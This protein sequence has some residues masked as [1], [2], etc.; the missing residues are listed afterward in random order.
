MYQRTKL[1]SF[2]TESIGIIPDKYSHYETENPRIYD[3]GFTYT[4]KLSVCRDVELLKKHIHKNTF[5]LYKATTKGYTPLLFCYLLNKSLDKDPYPNLKILI[6]EGADINATTNRRT[7]LIFASIY[8]DVR[9]VKLLINL[10]ANLDMTD[11]ESRTALFRGNYEI[12]KLLLE[13]GATISVDVLNMTPLTIYLQWD[14]YSLDHEKADI[15]L[16]YISKDMLNVSDRYGR[17]ALLLAKTDKMINKML[18]KG[19]DINAKMDGGK[20]VFQTIDCHISKNTMLRL[21]DNDV[22]TLYKLFSSDQHIKIKNL[23]ERI[24]NIIISYEKI[25]NDKC[26]TNKE[27]RVLLDDKQELALQIIIEDYIYET[28]KKRDTL[29]YFMGSLPTEILTDI[30]KKIY[31]LHN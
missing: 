20:T 25:E 28:T 4:H 6:D 26:D 22:Y 27:W 23:L 15:I 8:N 5:E 1:H 30:F 11:T 14:N 21:C 2:Q 12:T 9:T 3:Q 19:A 29:L 13:A 10:G 16:D 24:K 31:S 18:D 7:L 17:T